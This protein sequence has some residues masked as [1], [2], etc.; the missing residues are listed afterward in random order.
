MMQNHALMPEIQYSK[1]PNI[2][3]TH[4]VSKTMINK[5]ILVC[6]PFYL[7]MLKTRFDINRTHSVSCNS[8]ST[9]TVSYWQQ[10]KVTLWKSWLIRKR[11]PVSPRTK[12]FMSD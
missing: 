8:V 4:T 11:K 10:L 5:I 12:L 2:L 7:S 1:S 6:R 3:L 9:M